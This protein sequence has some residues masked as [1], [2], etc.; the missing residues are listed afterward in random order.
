[1]NHTFLK[2][3]ACCCNSEKHIVTLVLKITSIGNTL[4]VHLTRESDPHSLREELINLP[5][6]DLKNKVL[7][8]LR[9]QLDYT[10]D[11]DDPFLRINLF[12]SVSLPGP[13]SLPQAPKYYSQ[14]YADIVGKLEEVADLYDRFSSSHRP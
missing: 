13:A 6:P 12:E 10:I 2:Q 5:D 8:I 7:D 14:K 9:A 1:M 11:R 4:S 3:F